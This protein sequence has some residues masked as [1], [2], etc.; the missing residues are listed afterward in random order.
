M[1]G[2]V[3][4]ASI[5]EQCGF[6]RKQPHIQVT[7]I[8][9]PFQNFFPRNVARGRSNKDLGKFNQ[10]T[11][12]RKFPSDQQLQRSLAKDKIIRNRISP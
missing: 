3:V 11:S 6:L 10:S 9:G 1:L 2:V 8:C 5:A 4:F 7:S 12:I